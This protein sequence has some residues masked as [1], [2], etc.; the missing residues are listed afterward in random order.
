MP[1]NCKTTYDELLKLICDGEISSVAK[2]EEYF[3]CSA[4]AF[5][6]GQQD[7]LISVLSHKIANCGSVAPGSDLDDTD[8]DIRPALVPTDC[9]VADASGV[10]IDGWLVYDEF[11]YDEAGT[12]TYLGRI[13]TD[14]TTDVLPT[15]AQILC[16]TVAPEVAPSVSPGCLTQPI[17]FNADLVEGQSLQTVEIDGETYPVN[18][19][20]GWV[21][22]DLVDAINDL[23][24]SPIVAAN[25]TEIVFLDGMDR[26]IEMCFGE[27][28]DSIDPPF[29]DADKAFL[30][31][32]N[33]TQVI[34]IDLI[35][36][37]SSV[38]TTLDRVYNS[39]AYNEDDGYFYGSIPGTGDIFTFDPND[40]FN[41]VTQ[42]P[43]PGVDFNSGVYD[44]I[45]KW[46][47]LTSFS[48]SGVLVYDGD[49]TSL[50]YQ[51]LV[52]QFTIP[53]FGGTPDMIYHAPSNMIYGLSGN[54][55]VEID[56]VN[57]TAT[58][59]GPVSGVAN[60]THGAGYSTV[61]GGVYFSNNTTGEI[62][63]IDVDTLTG[64]VATVSTGSTS[65]D[66]AKA[67]FVAP[68]GDPA[69]PE[70]V[71]CETLS[72]QQK[73]GNN[74]PVKIIDCF[75]CEDLSN[76]L[77]STIVSIDNSITYARNADGTYGADNLILKYGECP[78]NNNKEN[79]LVSAC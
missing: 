67:L 6:T 50:T 36:G 3:F 16:S 28:I 72:S 14:G 18:L 11:Y 41:I 20:D 5:T 73:P 17:C 29:P 45:N 48:G 33:P 1:G 47:V 76:P 53:G 43:R 52:K 27:I 42:F 71:S 69:F 66:G 58:F 40:S 74:V 2:L 7:T 13:A 32:G 15:G 26:D 57:E 23:S 31:Q 10:Q 55:L 37:S 64:Q 9:Y 25:G 54:S 4:G 70:P 78:V 39:F 56:V 30:F 8:D 75:T 38:V 34:A 77:V 65:N 19:A 60:E 22:Q 24:G 61:D 63:K 12:R 44:P 68:G 21:T 79:L 59:L 46:Y 35:D 49:P 62:L 51:T